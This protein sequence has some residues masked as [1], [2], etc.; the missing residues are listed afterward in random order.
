M[1]E[2]ENTLINRY[3][4]HIVGI[5]RASA[6]FNPLAVQNEQFPL[7]INYNE[8]NIFLCLSTFPGNILKIGP[9][10]AE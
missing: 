8:K 1:T 6:A 5:F 2:S 9:K 3:L 10:M 7:S 4:G